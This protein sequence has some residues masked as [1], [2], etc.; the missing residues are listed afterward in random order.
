MKKILGL[1]IIALAL[2][3]LPAFGEGFSEGSVNC[4]VLNVRAEASDTSEIVTQ[5]PYGTRLTLVYCNG[6]NWYCVEL[7]DGTTGF[8]YA[9][10]ITLA[11][12]E[13]GPE[14]ADKIISFAKEQLGKPYSYGASGPN[15]FDC[16]GFTSYV[17]AA[18]G[19]SLPRTSLSQSTVGTTVSKSEL[20]PGDLVFFATGA[21]GKVSHVGIYIGDGN[22]IHAATGQGKISIN[23]LS[24][25]YYASRYLWAKRVF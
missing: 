13:T 8:C 6:L 14:S 20:M 17:Y 22:I 1:T 5:I 25:S 10:Y 12:S 4:D 18:N 19:I 21:S 24:Q 15:A 7:S 2:F 9:D 16:S 23:S 3:A 11:G